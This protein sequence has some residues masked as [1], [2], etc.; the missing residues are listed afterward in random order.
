MDA[1]FTAFF[2][3]VAL[4]TAFPLGALVPA[5]A[6]FAFFLKFRG[7]TQTPD[8]KRAVFWTLAAG[9][10]WLAYALYKLKMHQWS[11]T[12][13]API[14]VDLLLLTPILYLFTIFGIWN[15]RRL[16]KAG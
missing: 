15:V 12:V 7:R 11:K 9:L 3:P 14:R 10:V 1:L 13:V 8:M 5:G 6:F 4:L 2:F 16:F